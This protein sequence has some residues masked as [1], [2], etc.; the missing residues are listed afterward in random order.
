MTLVQQLGVV[1][2]PKSGIAIY[3]LPAGIVSTYGGN[4][5]HCVAVPIAGVIYNCYI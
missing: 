2:M 3:N 1:L 5:S 4:Q